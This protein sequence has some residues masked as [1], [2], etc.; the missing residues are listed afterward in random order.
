MS[1]VRDTPPHPAP[2]MQR[3]V[4]IRREYNAWVADETIEDY[5]LRY[6]PKSF[7]KWSE[8]RVASTALGATSFLALEAIGASIAL[9][10]GLFNAFW[11]I[12]LVSVFIFLM[13]IPISVYAARYAVDID[14]LTRGSGFGYLGSTFSSLVYASFTFIFFS[15]EASIMASAL[16][17]GLGIPLWLGYLICSVVVIPLV[18]YGITMISR[19]QAWTQPLWLVLLVL[20]YA[21]LLIRWPNELHGLMHASY[22]INDGHFDWLLV[23]AAATV[24]ASMVAQIG[25][26]VDS[27]RFMPPPRPG[28]AWRWWTAVLAAGPGWIVIGGAKMLGGAV[29]AY[30]AVR[31]GMPPSEAIK[32]TQMYLVG[33]AQV[34]RDP[35]G[36]L[37]LTCLFVTVSQIKINVNNAYAGSLAWSNFFARLTHAHPGR[38]VWLVFNVLIGVALIKVGIFDVLEGMLGFYANF[39]VAWMGALVA[40]LVVNKPL[41]LSPKGI[42]FRRAYLHDV[43]PVG[44]VSMGLGTLLALSAFVGA[45]GPL[46]QAFST[47]IGFVV[48]FCCAPLVAW[49]TGGKYY[50]ARQP[51]PFAAG[52]SRVCGVCQK[53]YEAEDMAHC[54]AY[55]GNICSLCC[56]LDARCKDVCKPPTGLGHQFAEAFTRY[57]PRI[58]KVALSR[59]MH[60]LACLLALALVLGAILSF[61]VAQEAHVLRELAPGSPALWHLMR[62][63]IACALVLLVVAIGS[64]WLLLTSDSRRV[65]QDES[66]RQALLLREE[67]SAHEI[68]DGELQAAR[69]VAE[70]ANQAKSRFITT[71]SHELRTP[72]NSILGYAQILERDPGL[73]PHRQAALNVIRKSGDHV[74]SLIDGL[75]DIARIETGRLALVS[76]EIR[77]PDFLSQLADIFQLEARHKHIAFSYQPTQPLPLAVRGD[78]KRV[79]QLLINLLGNAVK[80]TPRGQVTLRAR[81]AN[82]I[83][84]FEIEDTGA[85]IAA[86]DLERIFLPFERAEDAGAVAGGVGLGLTISKMLTGLMGGELTVRSAVGQGSCFTVRLFLPAVAHP[87]LPV[88]PPAPRHIT[89]H[90]GAPR[91]VLVVDD[92]AVDRQLL[93]DVLTPLGFTVLQAASGVEALRVASQFVP[94]LILL[95][96]DMPGIDG[97][98]TARLL[99]ANRI[100]FAPILIV[101]ANAF[102]SDTRNEVGI[103]R[104]DFIVKPLH[105]DDLLERMRAKLDLVW[106]T[107]EPVDLPDAA[108]AAGHLPEARFKVLQQLGEMGYVR[109]ILENLDELDRQDPRYAT[110]TEALRYCVQ[111]FDL[112]GFAR[113]LEESRAAAATTA[114]E[115]AT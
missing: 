41:G 113:V 22:G 55:G 67:I 81:Y 73:P 46:A 59:R 34:L 32:P 84:T 74:V 50:I 85:G 5:A 71:I 29:L 12:V 10:H 24:V 11:A 53:S 102:D 72:L 82:E 68:T 99:R 54:P 92:A 64:C 97:W 89:G 45:F 69:Q 103:G 48:A 105:I 76:T 100:S 31:Q 2:P 52:S 56:S 62:I 39:A 110:I 66:N 42:E 65:A 106:T 16:E 90:A 114:T 7:R 23:G 15:L 109:G 78:R 40:D 6:T 14:L 18:M 58:L 108:G 70:R 86:A 1:T 96:I 77:L 17:L 26:Q 27:L 38:L 112:H 28:Q 91:R 51:V 25:Q 83:A 98:E 20:P 33:F 44:F 43:N 13:G 75:L 115:A 101:S 104:E 79:A 8:F 95:D 60:Y 37:V 35:A 47:G 107:P 88:K 4:P 49:W 63:K 36:I 111:R 21:F 93:A 9:D 19:L 80:Y 3:I 30:L 57:A 94:D 87:L 61:I